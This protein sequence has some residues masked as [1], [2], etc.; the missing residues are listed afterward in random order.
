MDNQTPRN[1][2]FNINKIISF[3]CASRSDA[4]THCEIEYRQSQ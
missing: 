2:V 3:K 4:N 1:N